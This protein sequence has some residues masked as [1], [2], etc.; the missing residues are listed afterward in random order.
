[1]FYHVPNI[2]E[3][4]YHLEASD[5]PI[6]DG[7]QLIMSE[8]NSF[9]MFETKD[10]VIEYLNAGKVVYYKANFYINLNYFIN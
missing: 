5:D 1:M 10:Y 7:L 8:P 2:E 4:L 3:K 9:V 6:L